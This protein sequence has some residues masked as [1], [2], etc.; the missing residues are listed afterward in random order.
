LAVSALAGLTGKNQIFCTRQIQGY[1]VHRILLAQGERYFSPNRHHLFWLG[2]HSGYYV[3]EGG[4]YK[5]DMR[6]PRF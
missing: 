3:P 5:I 1:A 4:Q 2:L 6:D